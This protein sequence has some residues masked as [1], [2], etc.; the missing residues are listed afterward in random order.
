M[1]PEGTLLLKR[2]DV[3]ALLSIEECI[4]AVEQ[5]FRLQGAGQT[6]PPG[7]LGVHAR[8]GGF[9]IKA[10][11]LQLDRTYFAAKTNANFPHNVQRHGLPLIQGVIVLCDGEHGY[12]L[13]LM[14]S[15]EITIQRTGAA[16]AVAAKYLA[17]ADAKVAT[18]CGCGNQGRISLR[19]LSKVRP[20]EKVFA[21]DNDEAQAQ[22]FARELAAE[23][24][25]EVTAVSDL[26]DAVRQ[27]DIC[28]T[29]TP[30]RAPFLQQDYVAPGTFVA[31][32]GAD[33]PEK[34]ELDP[35]L[36]REH[37]LVVDLLEQ[38]AAFGELHHALKTERMSK[39]DVHAELGQVVAGL[40]S[41][42]TSSE[43]IIIFDSTGMALQDVVSAAAVYEKAMRLGRGALMN[44]AD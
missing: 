37:K 11:L 22:R 40:K 35:S 10:G 5:V 27:S 20:I 43:E 1:K 9:H 38:C 23:L 24:H 33:S 7:V 2:Q 39:D 26:R 19:A 6:V 14:D 32:V 3:A 34:Q 36:L 30:A 12:P 42:R 18:I 13:A 17:R 31:A 15:I 44:F 28:V 4:A 29:C 21:Y 8:D 16:T 25:I 41:G